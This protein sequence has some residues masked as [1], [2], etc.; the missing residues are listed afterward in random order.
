MRSVLRRIIHGKGTAIMAAG[1][2]GVESDPKGNRQLA[3]KW[4]RRLDLAV[5]PCAPPT[6]LVV[7]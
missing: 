2:P 5:G 6:K 4:I 1:P 7:T 3:F